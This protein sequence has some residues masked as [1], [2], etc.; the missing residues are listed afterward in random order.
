MPTTAG[1]SSAA[2]KK[3]RRGLP[4]TRTGM[5]DMQCFR[6]IKFGTR[7][8]GYVSDEK[9]FQKAF[10]K[11]LLPKAPVVPPLVRVPTTSLF[12]VDQEYRY[13]NVFWNK[14]ASERD[15]TRF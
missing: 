15:L 8:D 1:S 4:K 7:C 14:T 9:A 6:C 12:T 10:Q 5:P 2:G 13:F 11:A 3:E